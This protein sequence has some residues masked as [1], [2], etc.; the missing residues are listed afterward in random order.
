M[1]DLDTGLLYCDTEVGTR[2]C[3]GPGCIEAA[4]VGS[5]CCS[6]ECGMKLAK[7]CVV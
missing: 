4:R 3:F 1:T 5:K 2:Q 7:R 6:D